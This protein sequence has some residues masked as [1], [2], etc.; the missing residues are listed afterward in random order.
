M[1]FENAVKTVIQYFKS[2]CFVIL[3]VFSIVVRFINIDNPILDHHAFRQTETA[4]VVQTYINEGVSIF[5]YQ[6]PVLGEPYTIILECPVYQVCAY[7]IHHLLSVLRLTNNLDVSLR[8]TSILFFYISCL[9]LYGFLKMYFND[10]IITNIIMILYLFLPYIIFWSRTSMIETCAVAFACAYLYFYLRCIRN[11]RFGILDVLCCILSGCMGYL[12][13]STTMIPA[14]IFISFLILQQAKQVGLLKCTNPNIV[15]N[16]VFIVKNVLIALIPAFI[17]FLW[18]RY[19]DYANE[20]FGFSSFTSYNMRYWNFGTITQRLTPHVWGVLRNHINGII[21]VIPLVILWCICIKHF[22]KGKDNKNMLILIATLIAPI[23]TVLILFNLYYRH[24]YYMM[25][26]SYLLC[27]HIGVLLY[28]ALSKV[29]FFNKKIVPYL[30]L[31]VIWCVIVPRSLYISKLVS[32][33]D[34]YNDQYRRIANIVRE[35]TS[36]EDNLLIVGMSWNP[37][38]AYYSNRKALMLNDMSQNSFE[39]N[40]EKFPVI[41]LPN[42]NEWWKGHNWLSNKP[43]KQIGHDLSFDIYVISNM[44]K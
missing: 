34:I 44:K 27:I 14:C 5:K 4:I 25:S 37:S 32:N 19:A 21:P 12:S 33:V 8:V 2:Y 43:I 22:I 13:K 24:D 16:R 20:L 10:I 39:E 31:I 35:H 26:F 9:F 38:V 29:M 11:E 18:M 30:V 15:N 23:T 17:G 41:V 3:I 28:T 42:G 6:I 36:P 1:T 40:V 7:Y